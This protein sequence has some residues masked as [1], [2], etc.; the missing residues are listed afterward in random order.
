[1]RVFLAS[2]YYSY[3]GLFTWMTPMMYFAQKIVIPLT[4]V[5]FFSLVGAFGGSQPLDFYLIGNAMVVAATGGSFMT[6][7]ISEER[8]LGT[9]IYLVGSPANR[10]ALFF[11]RAAIYAA[12]GVLYVVM[13]FAWA[14]AVFGLYLPV[15]S[16][17]GIFAAM[18]TGT[19][20]VF[21]LGLLAGALA[22]LVLDAAALGYGI[23]LVLL[24]VSGA[25]V[26]LSELPPW[27]ALVGQ[28]L[29]LTRSIE[30]ARSIAAGNPLAGSLPL[31]LGD[32][33]VGAAYGLIGSLL[34]NWIEDQARRGDSLARV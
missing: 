20:A 7:A 15:S 12:D 32:L 3:R 2:A 10:V 9:L 23:V 14:M 24:L 1:M 16:W 13:A 25:N 8:G 21:G 11:G 17:G 26:P 30:A 5:G 28:V 34:F 22:Y 29:P 6:F 27:L 4:Q 19:V 18:V 31:L 33:A